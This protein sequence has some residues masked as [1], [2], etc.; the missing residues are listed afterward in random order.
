MEMAQPRAP[1]PWGHIDGVYGRLDGH[2]RRYSMNRA[3]LDKRSA[4]ETP[5]SACAQARK[6]TKLTR[7]LLFIFSAAN[8]SSS[9]QHQP[10]SHTVTTSGPGSSTPIPSHPQLGGKTI[11]IPN[12]ASASS[13]KA[14]QSDSEELTDPDADAEGQDEE[15]DAD[16][17]TDDEVESEDGYQ[18]KSNGAGSGLKRTNGRVDSE[19]LDNQM[20]DS[21][22]NVSRSRRRRV[23]VSVLIRCRRVELGSR[24]TTSLPDRKKTLPKQRRKSTI[25]E[26]SMRQ[27]KTTIST[28]TNLRMMT[29]MTRISASRRAKR[30]RRLGL[31]RNDQASGLRRHIQ[32]VRTR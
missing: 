10:L 2:W 28:W 21:R 15:S 1:C 16:G 23:R 14:G 13:S 18:V 27:G 6:I 3:C 5:K 4:P 32:K 29:T 12:N 31:L 11:F 17:V 20:L 30:R 19:D 8:G 25:M 24:A 9:Y 7:P 22:R 26:M